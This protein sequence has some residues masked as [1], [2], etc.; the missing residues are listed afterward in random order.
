MSCATQKSLAAGHIMSFQIHPREIYGEFATFS[1]PTES[2]APTT[3]LVSAYEF[4]AN[5][6]ADAAFSAQRYALGF[7]EIC[8]EFICTKTCP[9][10]AL[11]DKGRFAVT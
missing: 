1:G 9:C 3:K 5:S 4:A 8:G 6:H 11:H 2:S 7:S 10:H